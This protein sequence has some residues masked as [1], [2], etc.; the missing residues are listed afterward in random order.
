M[1]ELCNC[2][3]G[4]YPQSRLTLLL[5]CRTYLDILITPPHFPIENH[6]KKICFLLANS[7]NS[8]QENTEFSLKIGPLSLSIFQKERLES[9]TTI[10]PFYT[11]K[12][13]NPTHPFC[14][15]SNL[16][17]TPPKRLHPTQVCSPA[18]RTSFIESI[19]SPCLACCCQG[20]RE[21]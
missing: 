5:A 6:K 15:L 16:Y 17:K 7:Q 1:D 4:Q 8:S 20:W 10:L 18:H 19:C 21:M 14:T 13:S 12:C 2:W 9:F 11:S 3:W